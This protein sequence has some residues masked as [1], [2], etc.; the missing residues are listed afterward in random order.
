MDIYDF[1]IK[2]ID[3]EIVD[4]SKYKNKVLLIVNTASKCGFTSQYK[5]LEEL[6]EKYGDKKFEI[7]GFPCDQFNN[8]EPGTNN[9]IKNFCEINYGVTFQLFDKIDVKGEN[10][11]P[12][13]KYLCEVK[14]GLI[15][16][17]I[18]WNFSKFLV[19]SKGNVCNRFAPITKPERLI[20][21]IEELISKI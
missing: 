6:Y 8:Q 12:L 1:K 7:L 3:G 11:H 4:F 18:K 17:S 16:D 10:A 14:S 19:D 2:A 5:G 15:T 21:E 20:S 9:E 13:F